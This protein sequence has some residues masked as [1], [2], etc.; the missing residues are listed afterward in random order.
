MLEL[1]DRFR[2]MVSL[3]DHPPVKEC[4]TRILESRIGSPEYHWF[5]I[6]LARLLGVR[7]R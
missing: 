4:I 3:A 6:E 5:T 2:A 7:K 1:V